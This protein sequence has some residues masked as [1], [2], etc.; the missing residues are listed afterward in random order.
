MGTG[1]GRA[2]V[3]MQGPQTGPAG[4]PRMDHPPRSNESAGVSAPDGVQH[5]QASSTVHQLPHADGAT[6]APLTRGSKGSEGGS[7][8]TK[9][10][11]A[12]TSLNEAPPC[13]AQLAAAAAIVAAE[14]DPPFPTPFAANG[15]SWA[16]DAEAEEAE[17]AAEAA[18]VVAAGNG[19]DNVPGEAPPATHTHAPAK[20]TQASAAEPTAKDAAHLAVAHGRA[21]TGGSASSPAAAP[22]GGSGG[23]SESAVKAVPRQQQGAGSGNPAGGSS[24]GSEGSSS[25]APEVDGELEKARGAL[26]ALL[27]ASVVEQLPGS[28]RLQPRGLV[29]TGNTCFLNCTLQVSD[30]C[31][32]WSVSEE[33]WV[34]SVSG[35]VCAL[36]VSVR[37]WGTESECPCWGVRFRVDLGAT[38]GVR[39]AMLH[40]IK[41]L[42]THGLSNCL[43]QL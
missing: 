17:A 39:A 23:V 8:A 28:I 6:E 25:R 21:A 4:T 3:S 16:S 31:G 36:G 19:Q 38:Q 40:F 2:V 10:P 43:P 35:G 5:Q 20:H 32:R 12:S 30:E 15:V 14:V 24:K 11:T 42:T 41:P 9:A 33:S 34:T 22:V 26:V 13:Q 27:A 7:R 1:R 18:A 29:N 37:V